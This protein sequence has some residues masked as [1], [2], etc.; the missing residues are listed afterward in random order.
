M[1]EQL[2]AVIGYHDGS[3]GQVETWL[4]ES[5]GYRIHCFI[6]DASEL[7]VVDIA[8]ENSKRSNKRTSFPENGTFKGRPLLAAEN[9]VDELRKLNISRVLSLTGDNQKRLR[10]TLQAC[11]AGFELISAIHPS[12]R[13]LAQ[14]I[15]AP[16]VWINADSIVGYKAD[17][18]RA[19]ILNTR[20]LVEHHNV[21][22]EGCQLDP[23][24]V[25]AGNVTIA[26]CAHVHTAA[27]II[28][29]ITV[30]EN[31]IV[32]A[33]AVVTKDVPGHST[34]VGVPARVIK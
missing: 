30:G 23:G 1:K 12:V 34:V 5:T 4:E 7:P 24:V 19:V 10:Q 6:E 32:G 9:W 3:A 8:R 17:I 18:S 27:V 16:G 13:F 11:E 33:G 14:S 15:I 22:R 20:V 21:L 31:A 25:T 2:V 29:R 26:S 28:N